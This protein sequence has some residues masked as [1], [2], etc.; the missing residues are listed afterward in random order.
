MCKCCTRSGF[1]RRRKLHSK[2]CDGKGK[3]LRGAVVGPWME[4]PLF[5]FIPWLMALHRENR[6]FHF[7]N[8]NRGFSQWIR[9]QRI[10]LRSLLQFDWTAWELMNFQYQF[11]KKRFQQLRVSGNDCKWSQS[12]EQHH[13]KL[14]PVHIFGLYSVFHKLRPRL[15]KKLL[16]ASYSNAKISSWP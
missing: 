12:N 7:E 10:G 16:K 6:K 11:Q 14:F 8:P 4:L 5:R 9:M 1:F 2:T 13:K 3:T 15:N